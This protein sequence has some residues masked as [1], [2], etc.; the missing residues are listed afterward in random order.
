MISLFNLILKS[1]LYLC[2]DLHKPLLKLI[3]NINCNNYYGRKTL[4]Q[5]GVHEEFSDII[6]EVYERYHEKIIEHL[7]FTGKCNF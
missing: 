1:E 2:I 5:Y 3:R 7:E 4:L 6:F